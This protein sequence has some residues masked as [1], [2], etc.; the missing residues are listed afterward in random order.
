MSSAI[1]YNTILG[2]QFP[3]SPAIPAKKFNTNRFNQ[4]VRLALQIQGN[5]FATQADLMLKANW[6]TLIAAT[7]ATRVILSPPFSGTKISPSKPLQTNPDTNNTYRGLPVY[8]GEGT[9]EFS[10]TFLDVDASVLDAFFSVVSPF[11][12]SNGLGDNVAVGYWSNNDGQIFSTPTWGGLPCINFSDRTRG[13]DGLNSSDMV[14]FSFYLTPNWDG[15]DT[16]P[17]PSVPS[18]VGSVNLNNYAW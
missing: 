1:Q 6:D 8:F 5:N 18:G 11:T 16:L 12:M 9:A 4:V 14:P 13:S 7:D 15:G 2:N 17:T 3:D 10:A